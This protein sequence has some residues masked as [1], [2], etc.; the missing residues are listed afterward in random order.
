MGCLRF[1]C[2]IPFLL[3]VTALVW[4]CVY[5]LEAP[6]LAAHRAAAA[7][8]APGLRARGAA[9][10]A[11]A[12][13]L[14]QPP[15]QPRYVPAP[16]P[17][18]SPLDLELFLLAGSRTLAGTAAVPSFPVA[19]AP[20]R[21]AALAALLAA[22]ADVNY[23]SATWSTPLHR[24]AAAGFLAVVQQLVA[25]GGDAGAVDVYGASVAT[26]A[27]REGHADVLAALLALKVDI[28]GPHVISDSSD[29]LMRACRRG[30]EDCAELLLRA[31]ASVD[32]RDKQGRTPLM[33]AVQDN[34]V[35]MVKLLLA[36]KASFAARSA[37]GVSAA[38]WAATYNRD[39][40]IGLLNAEGAGIEKGVV[41]IQ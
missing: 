26:V 29:A 8:A 19:P 36:H 30:H 6:R 16:E 15:Q 7:Q 41:V 21:Q 24:A 1:C 11:S 31:G 40:I 10:P 17:P 14:L 33:Y 39:E 5:L 2:S 23:R 35:G 12:L 28:S 3:S 38:S 32:T 13:S 27:A 4:W 18:P 22:G 37:D 25:A 9:A 20:S 34:R